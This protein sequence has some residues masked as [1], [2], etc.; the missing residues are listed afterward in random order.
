MSCDMWCSTRI[1]F[2]TYTFYHVYKWSH[3]YSS[4]FKPIVFVFYCIADDTNLFFHN[5]SPHT[6]INT[7][8]NKLCKV[9]NWCIHN[10][11]TVNIEKPN[12]IIL[13]NHQ[14]NFFWYSIFASK[15]DNFILWYNN[16][17]VGE[18]FRRKAVFSPFVPLKAEVKVNLPISTLY[19]AWLWTTVIWP[20]KSN[21]CENYILRHFD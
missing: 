6:E 12:Y 19:A 5:K 21:V 15:C 14:T 7:I 11:L 10:K 13:K 8:N 2:G 9:S 1:Y 17:W 20:S 3:S 16:A 18:R 4:I